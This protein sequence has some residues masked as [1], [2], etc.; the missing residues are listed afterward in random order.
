MAIEFGG[1]TMPAMRDGRN[2]TILSSVY[3]NPL[4][5]R[6][7]ERL[8]VLEEVRASWLEAVGLLTRDGL[9]RIDVVLG[10][11]FDKLNKV[12]DLG[13]LTAS[14]GTEIE[15][16][17]GDEATFV[18]DL[19]A[20]RDLFRPTQFIFLS[21]T[22]TPDDYAIARTLE[23][24]D[25]TG[26]LICTILSVA[27]DPG[28]HSDWEISASSGATIA[29]REMLGSVMAARQE[30]LQAAEQTSEDR[31]VAAGSA[32]V[33][34]E[35]AADAIDAKDDAVAAQGYAEEWAVRPEN[36][37]VSLAAGGDNSTTFS[38][39]HWAKKA[40]I[41]ATAASVA[42]VMATDLNV[43]ATI[44]EVFADHPQLNARRHLFNPAYDNQSECANLLLVKSNKGAPS[45]NGPLSAFKMASAIEIIANP[46]SG[47]VY[48]Q[49]IVLRLNAGVGQF[50][51][52]GLEINVDN[53]NQDYPTDGSGGVLSFAQ[54]ILSNSTFPVTAAIGIGSI[55]TNYQYNVGLYFHTQYGAKEYTIWD[56]GNSAVGYRD[57]GTHATAGFWSSATSPYGFFA[58]GTYATAGYRDASTTPYGI[59]LIGTYATAALYTTGKILASGGELSLSGARFIIG[60]DPSND[61]GILNSGNT[62]YG[63]LA[64]GAFSSAAFQDGSTSPFGIALVGTYSNSALFTS[65][66]VRAGRLST[67]PGALVTPTE[68]GEITF[69]FT[70]NTSVTIKG[71]GTD[72]TVRSVA[73]TLA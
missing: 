64:N 12:L 5:K 30:V 21:R 62:G 59:E 6:V 40:Q 73:L 37:P 9:N 14:S 7:D 18:I 45:G 3:F 51:G 22:A 69:Q 39:L 16:N 24:N 10:P 36:T 47:N 17:E 32:A 48:G 52:S 58:N 71:K 61:I 27:G 8:H 41:F 35:A 46:G 34:A 28:P 70:S 33:A 38:A 57:S 50:S 72:G 29:Q 55:N 49:N 44:T 60:G 13:F 15:L 56:R 63:Y 53:Y 2:G 19:G 67:L 31:G 43:P 4:H 1:P 11:A 68:N 23:Y 25:S 20:R 66:R 26:V 65:G 42:M 54:Q